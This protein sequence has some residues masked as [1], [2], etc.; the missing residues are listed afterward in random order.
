MTA[1]K[2][3][4]SGEKSFLLQKISDQKC[5]RLKELELISGMGRERIEEHLKTLD[6]EGKISL[7]GDQ[8][9]SQ[10]TLRA[11]RFRLVEEAE[12]FHRGNPLLP[13]IPHATLK[14]TLPKAVSQ[15][16]FDRLLADTAEGKLLIQES[17]VIRVPDFTPKPTEQEARDIDR[18]EAAYREAGSLAKNKREMLEQLGMTQDRAEPYLGFLFAT[19][20]IIKLNEESFLHR[21]DLRQSHQTPGRPLCRQRDLDPGR[22]PRPIRQRPQTDSGRSGTLRQPQIHHAPRRCQG[23]LET[24]VTGLTSC[25]LPPTLLNTRQ[26]NDFIRSFPKA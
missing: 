18:I 13:G 16:A 12:R 22:I 20:R 9:V 25:E 19:K 21:G 10:E 17:D 7:L 3:L 23:R 6:E 1:L 11:W 5:V 15:K 14:Q 26:P 2:E 8:W 4:E 24:A